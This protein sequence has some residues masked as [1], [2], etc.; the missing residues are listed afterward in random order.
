MAGDKEP[1]ASGDS[2]QGNPPVD[3]SLQSDPK[4]VGYLERGLKSDPRLISMVEEGKNTNNK[5][6]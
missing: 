2:Q 3:S 4:L 1:K 6:R 5:R